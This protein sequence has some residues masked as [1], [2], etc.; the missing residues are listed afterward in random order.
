[1]H[2]TAQPVPGAADSSRL[3]SYDKLLHAAQACSKSC[4]RPVR[5][6]TLCTQ[7]WSILKGLC[8][9]LARRPGGPGKLL[10]CTYITLF[11]ERLSA[12]PRLYHILCFAFTLVHN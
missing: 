6:P 12:L 7:T 11:P 3:Q 9:H 10:L 4:I 1:M 8:S 5:L 2:A